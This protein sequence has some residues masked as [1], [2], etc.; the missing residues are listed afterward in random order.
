MKYTDD[1]TSIVAHFDP[2]NNDFGLP[3]L[4]YD[5]S[6]LHNGIVD[7]VFRI[8]VSRGEL[9]PTLG[10]RFFALDIVDLVRTGQGKFAEDLAP[11]VYPEDT[12]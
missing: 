12:P 3:R 7:K 9:P 2:G 1:P 10:L 8:L 5:A 6:L 11:V 4:P